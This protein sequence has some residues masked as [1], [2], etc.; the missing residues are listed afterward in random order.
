VPVHTL[1]ATPHTVHLGGFSSQLPPALY[2]QSGDVVQVETYSGFAHYGKAPDRFFTPEF[3]EICQTLPAERRVGPGP[4][5]LTGPIYVEGAEP[6]DVL[7]VRLQAITPRL[8]IGFNAIR[9]GWGALPGEFDQPRLRFIDL[10][11]DQ[12]VAEFPPGSGIRVP[13]RPFF[14]I[15][16]VATEETSRSS[17]PPATMVATSTTANCRRD[18]EFFCRSL[19][20]VPFF[21]WGMA[22]PLKGTEKLM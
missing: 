17:I 3:L 14:G 8:P 6:G 19:C 12:G 18:P 20:P 9:P 4:H 1:K 5:L 21:R 2:V 16:G 10:D 7:E 22:T 15:L 11:I 13:I